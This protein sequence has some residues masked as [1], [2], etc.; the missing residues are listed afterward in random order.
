MKNYINIIASNDEQAFNDW[1]KCPRY[2]SLTYAR[3][4]ARKSVVIFAKVYRVYFNKYGM[5][6]KI[7]Q[8]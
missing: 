4:A 5:L 8:F 6:L 1:E 7:K 2:K 3:C